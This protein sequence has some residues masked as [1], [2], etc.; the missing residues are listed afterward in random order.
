VG[1]V[2]R[3]KLVFNC[4]LPFIAIVSGFKDTVPPK[5]VRPNTVCFSDKERPI[6]IVGVITVNTHLRIV[7]IW[8]NNNYLPHHFPER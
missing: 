7:L 8:V 2:R 5:S 3:L 6:S 1:T 4:D